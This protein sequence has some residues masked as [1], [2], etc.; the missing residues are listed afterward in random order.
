MIQTMVLVA[1]NCGLL[2]GLLCQLLQ[3]VDIS[4]FDVHMYQYE[5]Y[6]EINL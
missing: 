5:H 3:K 4:C 6:F 2:H 1:N